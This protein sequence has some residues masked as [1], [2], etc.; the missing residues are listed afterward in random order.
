MRGKTGHIARISPVSMTGR[1][2][3]SGE[4][5]TPGIIIYFRSSKQE[6]LELIIRDGI[7]IRSNFKPT[8]G[9]KKPKS[10]PP[11]YSIKIPV[12]GTVGETLRVLMQRIRIHYPLNVNEHGWEWLRDQLRDWLAA[13]MLV[14]RVSRRM[15]SIHRVETYDYLQSD[16]YGSARRVL[17]DNHPLTIRKKGGNH[18][19]DRYEDKYDLKKEKAALIEYLPE[20]KMGR[21]TRIRK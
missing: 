8:N 15:E 10:R 18:Y 5:I 12:L 1:S 14:N 20:G 13:Q 17:R 9:I 6:N 16:V 19:K 4:G 2:S 7:F 21:R 11:I 3:T